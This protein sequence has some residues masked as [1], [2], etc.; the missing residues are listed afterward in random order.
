ML[1]NVP[2]D[3][4]V[5]LAGVSAEEVAA[6]AARGDGLPAAVVVTPSATGTP[7]AFVADVLRALDATARQLLPGWLPEADQL[8]GPRGAA[9]AAIRA[10]AIERAHLAGHPTAFLADLAERALTGRPARARLRR[11]VR[12]A[13]LAHVIAT[14]F[15]RDR[16]VLAMPLDAEP[17]VVAGSEW[18]AD[19]G[20]LGVWLTG[21][22][23]PGPGRIATVHLAPPPAPST[24]AVLGEP[25]P[26]SAVEASLEAV[27]ARQEWAYGRVWNGTYQPEPLRVPIR[28]DL[29]WPAERVVVELDG[30]EHCRPDRYDDDRA[31]DVRLQLDGYA[32]LRFT[33]ARVRHDVQ[34]VAA[35]IELLIR[36]RRQDTAKGQQGG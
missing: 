4:V 34:T 25:H 16:L 35:Q 19:H 17:S 29:L 21:T 3:R 33:N 7:A 13:G 12:V 26:R 23:P 32:V 1:R 2:A 14:G 31:R 15:R 22:G 9:V 30:P 11:E 6:V 36:T 24:P 10:V 20:R 27:L 5:H 28:P 8:D 18:L